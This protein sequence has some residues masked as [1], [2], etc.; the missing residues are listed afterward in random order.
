MYYLNFYFYQL[1]RKMYLFE[2]A[3]SIELDSFKMNFWNSF[4]K[5][6]TW[7]AASYLYIRRFLDIVSVII[8][9]NKY[10]IMYLIIP[11]MTSWTMKYFST[12][13]WLLYVA[14][15]IAGS[16]IFILASFLLVQRAGRRERYQ[17]LLEA[18]Q[19]YELADIEALKRRFDAIFPP[20]G[21]LDSP[22]SVEVA[23]ADAPRTIK[24]RLE[25]LED[26]V[27]SLSAEFATFTFNHVVTNQAQTVQVPTNLAPTVQA[28]TNRAPTFQAPTNHV[29]P[30]HTSAQTRTVTKSW[31]YYHIRFGKDSRKCSSDLC[32]FSPKISTKNITSKNSVETIGDFISMFYDNPC[33]S[34]CLSFVMIVFILFVF[35]GLTT[36]EKPKAMLSKSITFCGNDSDKDVSYEPFKKSLSSDKSVSF[37]HT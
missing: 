2:G 18:S 29:P 31:C 22:K 14:R 5:V 19:G 21:V 16:V 25:A 30:I 35:V 17:I 26:A 7:S 9:N 33:H 12:N 1:N 20:L 24:E 10:V 37:S 13:V 8:Q 34:M 36:K 3:I 27:R 4:Q 6:A 28:P 32:T 11:I 15:L 23:V